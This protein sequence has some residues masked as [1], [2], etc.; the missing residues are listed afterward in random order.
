MSDA[1]E[2][3]ADYAKYCHWR[4]ERIKELRAKQKEGALTERERESLLMLECEE[5]VHDS[6]VQLIMGTGRVW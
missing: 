4:R 2:A 6:T 3:L 5:M 1:A